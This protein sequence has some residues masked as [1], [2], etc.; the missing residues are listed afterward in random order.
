MKNNMRTIKKYPNRRLYD[1]ASSKYITVADVLS[2]IREGEDLRVVESE[3]G[4]DITRSVLV[5]IIIEQE[6]GESPIFT[7][8]MLTR[9]IRIYDDATQSIFGDMLDKNLQIYSE[10]RKCLQEHM[11]GLVST[12]VQFVQDITDRN[13]SVWRDVQD[14]F[15]SMAMY[16]TL[17]TVNECKPKKEKPKAEAKPKSKPKDEV[18]PKPKAEEK[19]KAKA[20]QPRAVQPKA[21]QPKAVQKPKADARAAI[22]RYSIE[23]DKNKK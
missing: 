8:E 13:L 23:G 17:D 16:G 20:V 9:F 2:I 15:M 21:V 14:S 22:T 18:K 12:P 11:E 5:Q 4:E 19:P 6:N 3:G 10:Q 7:T 1:T